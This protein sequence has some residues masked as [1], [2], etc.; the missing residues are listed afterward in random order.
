MQDEIVQV[1]VPKRGKYTFQF[2][3]CM[4]SNDRFECEGK[5]YI[6]QADVFQEVGMPMV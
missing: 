4:W 2:D 5:K 3:G 6:T 1:D